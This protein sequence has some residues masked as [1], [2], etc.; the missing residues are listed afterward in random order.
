MHA[1]KLVKKNA[2]FK[3]GITAYI[4]PPTHKKNTQRGKNENRR[5]IF[6]QK[7]RIEE[8]SAP[9]NSLV[10][11]SCVYNLATRGPP[12]WVIHINNNDKCTWCM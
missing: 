10:G 4:C 3:G 7:K 11:V 1:K 9:E 12:M 6:T 8:V 2:S 5:S